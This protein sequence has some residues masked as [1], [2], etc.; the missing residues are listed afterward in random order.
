MSADTGIV[1]VFEQKIIIHN[2][3]VFLG[4]FGMIVALY[5]L[6]GYFTRVQNKPAIT[7]IYLTSKFY[8]TNENQSF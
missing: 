2:L 4:K 3:K 1:P 6:H 5:H 8:L 7:T